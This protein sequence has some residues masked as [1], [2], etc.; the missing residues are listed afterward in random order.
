MLFSILIA[1]Y[2]NGK[3]FLDCYKSII[4]Q[5]YTDWEVI[6]V[7]DY[8]IDDSVQI[9]K[10][11]IGLDNRFH[12][13]IND[14]NKGCGFTKN[15]C[16]GLAKGDVLGFLDPDD[17]LESS[18]LEAMIKFHALNKHIALISSKYRFI[19]KK[20]EFIGLG[21]HGAHIPLGKS[22]LTYGEGA[23]TA[24]ATFKRKIYNLTEGID[25]KMTRAVDQDLYYKLE[26]QGGTYFIDEIL[27]R[28]RL[29]DN[30]ISRNENLYKSWYWHFYA[31]KKAFYRRKMLSSVI[32]NFSNS[33]FKHIKSDY[34]FS[35]FKFPIKEDSKANRIYFLFKSLLFSSS[36]EFKFKIAFL[37]KHLIN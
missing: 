34:Y 30:N 7:D 18:A 21:K 15:R 10:N 26:E 3:F 36:S 33:E 35:R 12:L 22:Y 16:A 5:T 31:K 28:Y 37:K 9:I 4:N 29:H 6:I 19:S 23:I 14:T 24:F 13:Y 11:I 25:E 20:G 2:N 8:S 27:Y 17:L 1:N 32:S